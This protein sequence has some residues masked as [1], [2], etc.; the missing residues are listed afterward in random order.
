M[1]YFVNNRCFKMYVVCQFLYKITFFS[2]GI[3]DDTIGITW[4]GKSE[5]TLWRNL[6][7][8]NYYLQWETKITKPHFTT[9]EISRVNADNFL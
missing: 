2:I 4:I 9:D 6:I 7:S 8:P 3:I 5:I 1:Q